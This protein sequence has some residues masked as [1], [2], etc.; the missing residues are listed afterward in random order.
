MAPT[1]LPTYTYALLDTSTAWIGYFND[2]VDAER[3][4]RTNSAIWFR[5]DGADLA[6]S[7]LLSPGNSHVAVVEATPSASLIKIT[8]FC[9]NNQFSEAWASSQDLASD[10]KA[11]RPYYISFHDTINLTGAVTEDG[12]NVFILYGSAEDSVQA[13]I[14]SPANGW[15]KIK[16]PPDKE[17]RSSLAQGAQSGD[18]E[19]IFCKRRSER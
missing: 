3:D 13:W 17:R 7:L 2:A 12:Q 18:G 1:T 9:L 5:R 4:L 11:A 15:V 16:P 6:L 14:V 8:V 19:H 10:G